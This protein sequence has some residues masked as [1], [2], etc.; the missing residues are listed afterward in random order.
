M[1]HKIAILRGSCGITLIELLV[2]IILLSV[3][4]LAV[5]NIDL[6]SRH[7]LLSSDR[8]LKLQNELSFT[9]E[10]I[11]K[12]VYQGVGDANNPPLEQISNGFRV[13]VDRNTT[14]TPSLSDDTWVSYT[15]TN[16]NLTCVIPGLSSEVISTHIVSGVSYSAMPVLP[17]P[18]GYKGLYILFTDNFTAVEIGLVARWKPNEPAGVD[19]PQVTMKTRIAASGSPH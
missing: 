18:A 11:S 1:R 15:L 6:F 8:R 9:L 13:R 10:H 2:A 4:A 12:N 3:V 16:N 19:N 17:L 5:G 14:P 7:H